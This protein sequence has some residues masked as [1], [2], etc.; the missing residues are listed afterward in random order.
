[1]H[2]LTNDVNSLTPASDSTRALD[3]HMIDVPMSTDDSE[4]VSSQMTF[5]SEVA[6][7]DR[8]CVV[9]GLTELMCDTVHL[10]PYDKGDKVGINSR[11]VYLSYSDRC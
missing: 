11:G 2:G 5:D 3:T 10:I 7:R 9:T 1:V 4:S 6:F 8:V